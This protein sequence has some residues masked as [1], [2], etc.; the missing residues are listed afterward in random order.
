MK[1][2]V[3]R[4]VC[5]GSANCTQTCPE[6]FQLEEGKSKVIVDAVPKEAE[7]KCREAEAGCPVQAISITE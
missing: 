6:V 4:D 1:A 7:A 3:D 5:I 2:H